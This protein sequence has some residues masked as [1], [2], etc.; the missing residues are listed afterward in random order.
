MHN[1]LDEAIWTEALS[2]NG[3]LYDEPVKLFKDDIQDI[4]KTATIMSFV[5][6]GANRMSEIASRSNEPATNLSRPLKKLIDLGFL[7]KDIPFDANEEKSKKTL[8]KIADPFVD[9]HYRFVVP[10]R[11]FIELG[12][13]APIEMELQQHFNEHTS[14]WWEVICR[15]AVTGNMIDGT[16]Y[17]VA[18]RW[19]GTVLDKEKKPHQ[20]ELDVVA[21]SL[22]KKKILIGE[23][24]WTSG[25]DAVALENELRW[26]ASMLPFAKGKEVVPV[27]F[28]KN[29]TNKSESSLTITPE[30]VMELMK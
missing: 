28:A 25:E 5:G 20:I 22:D 13:K 24:K 29:I 15:D 8:Y 23:C 7:G 19:W 4:V 14:K 16:L 12:R 17:G 3:T 10:M 11:S 6:V 2:V 9:F 27:I 26:K 30:D 1:S 18:K 21:E